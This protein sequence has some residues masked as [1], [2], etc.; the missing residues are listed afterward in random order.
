M[1]RFSPDQAAAAALL[2]TTVPAATS[3]PDPGTTGVLQLVLG[4]SF[5]DVV[6]RPDAA[7][8]APVDRPAATAPAST[9]AAADPRSAGA[10]TR[11]SPPAGSVAG[12]RTTL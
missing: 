4:P 3:V 2:A 11:G 10:F 1:I 7:G 9:P 8:R 12:R 5:D 6:P